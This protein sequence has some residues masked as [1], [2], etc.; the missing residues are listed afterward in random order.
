MAVCLIFRAMAHQS[1]VLAFGQMLEK[2]QGKF[3]AMVLDGSITCVKGLIFEQF[4]TVTLP[5]FGPGDF[6]GEKTADQ[7]LA[8][9]E[10][11]HP[12]VIARR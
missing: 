11:R 8:G 3:L 9:T 1:D 5:E 7:P 2:S 12:N 6:P 4:I 10:V